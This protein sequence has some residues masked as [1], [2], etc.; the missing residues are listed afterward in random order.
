MENLFQ[1]CA[2]KYSHNNLN[3]NPTFVVINGEFGLAEWY[4]GRKAGNKR[5]RANAAPVSSE[6]ESS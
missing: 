3:R 1:E 2:G 6:D 5:Q 4:P